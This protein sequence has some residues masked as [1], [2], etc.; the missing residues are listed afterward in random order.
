[1][2]RKAVFSDIDS[3]VGIY[4]ALHDKEEKGEISIG[5]IRG[6]YP[7]RITAM[8]ALER[9]DLFVYEEDGVVLGAGIINQIQVDVYQTAPWNYNVADEQVCVLHTLVISPLA[10]E[11]GIGKQFV[12]FYETYA[13]NHHCPELRMDTNERNH[14]ARSMYCNL[15]Y[16][17]IAVVST[18]FNGIPDVNLVLLE[19]HLDDDV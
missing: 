6:V 18:I 11:R 1:M 3:V 19:K 12:K 8:N 15:G 9:E 7:T 17:E 16:K 5:W 4:D 10:S 2:I 14:V 13:G